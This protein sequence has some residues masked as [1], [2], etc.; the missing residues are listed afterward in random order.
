[1]IFGQPISTLDSTYFNPVMDIYLGGFHTDWC[2][3]LKSKSKL[4]LAVPLIIYKEKNSILT[5]ELVKDK[6]IKNNER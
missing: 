1:M 4:K 3:L 6:K 5:W 2:I